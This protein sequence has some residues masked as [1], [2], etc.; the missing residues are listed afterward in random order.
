MLWREPSDDTQIALTWVSSDR[1]H[2]ER[3]KDTWRRMVEKKRNGSGWRNW[4]EA[5]QLERKRTGWKNFVYTLCERHLVL[6]EWM[7][8]MMMT[9]KFSQLTDVL[10]VVG[11]SNWWS[12]L[13][14]EHAIGF[15]AQET[16][17]LP[18]KTQRYAQICLSLESKWNL[19]MWAHVRYCLPRGD[20]WL[21]L[22][23]NCI[24]FFTK[25]SPKLL[26]ILSLTESYLQN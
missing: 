4:S 15:N 20:H 6:I 18:G 23:F 7:M 9:S 13:A 16:S 1:R 2:R 25:L 12:N 10:A 14:N 17:K 11:F 8:M 22:L 19:G 3:P 24:N 26:L 21:S 5:I